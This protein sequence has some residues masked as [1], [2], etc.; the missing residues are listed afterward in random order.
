RGRQTMKLIGNFLA[1]IFGTLFGRT[2]DSQDTVPSPQPTRQPAPPLPVPPKILS[3]H[4][5][6]PADAT[7]WPVGKIVGNIYQIRGV[8][9]RGGM[10]L[11]YCAH[12]HA[13]HR[14]IA[15]KVPLGRWEYDPTGRKRLVRFVDSPQA[16]AALTGEVRNWIGLVHPHVV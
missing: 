6:V 2:F 16:K 12:D 7:A 14:D 9:G 4:S 11:V 8:L 1:R 10:G 3:A 13:T 15:M 5:P